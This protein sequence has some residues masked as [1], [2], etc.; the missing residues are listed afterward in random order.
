MPNKYMFDS[1]VS[2]IYKLDQFSFKSY[3]VLVCYNVESLSTNIPLQETIEN[4][5]RHVYQQNDPQKY[6]I[7]TFRKFL[8]IATGG[9]LLDRGKSYCQINGVTVGSPLGPT[10]ANFFLAQ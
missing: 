2:F 4:V 3:H 7:E 8:Q 6:P 9:C 10:L 1:N 5:C